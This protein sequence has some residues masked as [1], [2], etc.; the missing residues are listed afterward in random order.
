LCLRLCL[1][2][3]S[4]LR[5]LQ[6]CEAVL[7]EALTDDVIQGIKQL[8]GGEATFEIVQLNCALAALRLDEA[9]VQRD[10]HL[11][12]VVQQHIDAARRISKAEMLP[13]MVQGMLG[14]ARVGGNGLMVCVVGD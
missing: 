2:L 8:Y 4:V 12:D 3:Y 7:K 6:A 13:D 10:Q 14:L 1:C 11:F 9:R 5:Q